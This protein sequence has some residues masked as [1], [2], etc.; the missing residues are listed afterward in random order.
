MTRKMILTNGFRNSLDKIDRFHLGLVFKRIEKILEFP[1]LGKPLHAPM[2]GFRSERIEKL[3]IIYMF[4]ND[5]VTFTFLNH[6]KHI[7]E[8]G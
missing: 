4:D 1:E 2:H 6:R 7:Y 5:S 3:R 8:M